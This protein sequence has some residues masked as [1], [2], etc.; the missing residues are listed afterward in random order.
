MS[1]DLLTKLPQANHGVVDST[2]TGTK[3]PRRL[4]LRRRHRPPV[5]WSFDVPS[6]PPTVVV[7][8]IVRGA[9]GASSAPPNRVAQ[10][11]ETSRVRS[12]VGAALFATAPPPDPDSYI[13]DSTFLCRQSRPL[14]DVRWK[15][16]GLQSWTACGCGG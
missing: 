9:A 5:R 7:D 16:R 12:G 1:E 2:C 6:A 4:S 8:G 15:V 10:E 14:D 11:G 13:D 3:N